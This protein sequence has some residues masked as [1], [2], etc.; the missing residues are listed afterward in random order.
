MLPTEIVDRCSDVTGVC[1]SRYLQPQ[2]RRF[3][4]R[5][6]P[7]SQTRRRPLEP[8]NS[9]GN[10]LDRRRDSLRQ[11]RRQ[12][13]NFVVVLVYS[14]HFIRRRSPSSALVEPPARIADGGGATTHQAT[15][16]SVVVVQG[17]DCNSVAV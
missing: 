13:S 4:W 7:G 5:H 1:P 16:T 9:A 11:R 12:P 10:V 8:S 6:E 17:F 3:L 2:Q 14:V 15:N